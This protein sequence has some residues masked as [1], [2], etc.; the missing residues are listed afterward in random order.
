MSDDSGDYGAGPDGA[1]GGGQ[2]SETA[3]R[4]G[5]RP[6]VDRD[7][8]PHDPVLGGDADDRSWRHLGYELTHASDVRDLVG[9]MRRYGW[10]PPLLGLALTGGARGLLE[11]ASE[12]F[13]MSKGYVFAGWE[14]ALAINVMFGFF[15]AAFSWFL[16]F[17]V[18]GSFAGYFSSVT[19]METAIFKVGGYLMVLFVPLF[20]VS[21]ALA[22]TIPA[23]D[24]A[25][26]GAD[27]T[28]DVARTYQQVSDTPQMRLVDTLLAGGWIVVGFLM[29]PVVSELY[30]V[31]RKA[32][33]L[34]VL[35]VTL[36]A[37]V[38][39]QLV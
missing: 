2:G 26:A 36:V 25:V 12:P 31:D 6:D 8:D 23:P 28:A 19:K 35:P 32:S 38:A 1:E 17:G 18:I 20:A 30:E 5:Y 10:L 22:L 16:Y 34:S 13:A 33:V 9:T 29:I 21:S 24:V 4:A 14:L 7:A 15:L 3:G 27:S 39:T 37:V 11:H